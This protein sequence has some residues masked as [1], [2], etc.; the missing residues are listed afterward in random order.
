MSITRRDF[1][2]GV[3]MT[4]AAGLAPID[5]LRASPNSELA[6]KTLENYPPALMGMRGSHPGSFEAAHSISRGRKIF[7]YA[8]LPLLNETYDLVIVGA[9]ISGLA[10]AIFYQNLVGKDK[11]ILL[12][13][14]HDDFGGH[15]KRNEFTTK[16][17][18]IIGYGG[19]ESFQS[20]RSIFSKTTMGMLKDLT[21]DLDELESCFDVNFYP[22]MGLSKGVYFDKQTF[23]VNKV[24]S[25]DPGGSVADD[26]PPNKR[27]GRSLEDFVGDFP[28]SDTDKADLLALMKDN[29]DYLAGM[30]KDEKDEWLYSHSY[31]HFLREKVGLSERAILYFQ[32]ATDDFQAVGIDAT[33][34]S[35]A[36]LCG[37]PGFEG[38]NLHPMDEESLAELNDPYTFHFPGGNAGLTRLMVRRLIPQSAPGRTMQD[39]V[40]AKMD[41]SQLDKAEHNVR[42]RLNSTVVN[43]RNVEGGVD[44]SYITGDKMYRVRAK[45]TILACYNMMIPYLMPEASAEQ[46]FALSQNVKAPLVYTNVIIKNWQSFVKLGVHNIYSPTAPYSLVKLDYPVDMGGYQH[47]RDPNKPICL[48]MVYVPSMPGSG[49]SAR[50]QS[51]KGRAQLLGMSFAE[52]EKMIRDQLQ[53]MLGE[54]GFNHET[55]ILAITVNRWSHGYSYIANTLFD[56][57]DQCDEWI[58]QARQPIGNVTIANSDSDWSP[59]AHAAIDQGHRAVTELIAMQKGAAK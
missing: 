55:D 43:V 35:D 13:D 32:R 39:M 19:S 36:R 15:A 9:G 27:N 3:A 54:A 24:V 56:D 37:L 46:K 26:V 47:P 38:M 31:T 57:E 17:G 52:H 2:N 58:E 16:D 50:E 14:N 21:I 5:I 40:M 23:G 25:G 7:D 53:G 42:L 49:L 4:V 22:D 33:P 51:M 29:T 45:Q 48:H 59:Y 12:L 30:S 34:C 44:L 8:A 1:L 41:Y 18:L 11:K 20:P 10:A 6:R 28:F